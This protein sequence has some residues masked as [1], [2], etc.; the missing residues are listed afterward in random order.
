MENDIFENDI[1]GVVCFYTMHASSFFHGRFIAPQ[2]VLHL[3]FDAAQPVRI[4]GLASVLTNTNLQQNE[5]F[6][7]L[8]SRGFATKFLRVNQGL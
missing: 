1:F 4:Q 2:F 8:L 5:A 6:Q 3:S 7:F